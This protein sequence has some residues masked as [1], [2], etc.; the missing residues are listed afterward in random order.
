M[1]AGFLAVGVNFGVTTV[2]SLAGFGRRADL[3]AL[4][5]GAAH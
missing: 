2:L 4:E 5:A 3:G 1:A